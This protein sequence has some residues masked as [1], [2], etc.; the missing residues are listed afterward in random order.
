MPEERRQPVTGSTDCNP[1]EISLF[2]LILEDLRTHDNNPFEQGFWALALHRLGNW[3]MNVQP[4]LLRAP[5]SILYKIAFKC[6]EW[7]CGISLPHSVRVGRRVRIWHHSG[8]IFNP[9]SIGDDVHLRNNTTIG[10]ASRATIGAV[11]T[12]G[13]RVDVGA[14]VCI[15]GR[16]HV[17]DDAIIGA[18]AVV[19]R[20]VPAGATVAGVPARV[21]KTREPSSIV[22]AG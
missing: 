14:N 22:H 7:T 10:V 12:I 5:F 13:N 6:V 9:K 19:V 2:R 21:I 15:L 8:M 18:G 17:G 4:K 16:I 1:K 20:D 3:R 11:P